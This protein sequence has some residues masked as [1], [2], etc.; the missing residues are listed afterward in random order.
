MPNL[1]LARQVTRHL[2]GTWHGSYGTARGPGHRKGDASLTIR[3]H[4]SNPNDIVLHSFAGNDWQPIKDELRRAGILP[5]WGGVSSKPAD[6]AAEEA[7]KEKAREEAAKQEAEAEARRR[8]YANQLWNLRQPIQGSL[9][10]AY[11]REAR[12]VGKLPL[13]PLD[14]LGFLPAGKADRKIPYPAMIA[15]HGMPEEYEPGRLR[16][17]EVSGVRLTFL[18]GPRKAQVEGLENGRKALG[19][20][21]GVPIVLAPPNDGLALC[22]AEGVE[23]ALS[24]H[25]A[26]GIGAWATGSANFMPALA[27]VVPSYIESVTIWCEKGKA[28]QDNA[29]ELQERLTA[30]GFEVRL[31]GVVTWLN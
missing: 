25:L 27:D 4:R 12:G 26:R 11:L 5:K 30:R 24:V 1:D 16:V 17:G 3:P 10:E 9:A 8:W 20:C 18:D 21:K 23:T 14:M 31:A 19:P 7:A 22:I 28:G 2:G 13:P 6:T 29:R 15:A